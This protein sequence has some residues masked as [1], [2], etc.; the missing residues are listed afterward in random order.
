[1]RFLRV[2]SAK[3]EAAAS[4]GGRR[5]VGSWYCKPLRF[6]DNAPLRHRYSRFRRAHP[7]PPRDLNLPEVAFG[8]FRKF[9]F[10]P[11]IRGLVIDRREPATHTYN[12]FCQ[13]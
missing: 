11:P 6:H 10:P 2:F 1:L 8:A 5:G 9:G 12:C 4:S 13:R 7:R 3:N